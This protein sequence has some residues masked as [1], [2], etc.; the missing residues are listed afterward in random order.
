M[1]MYNYT[2]SK[3]REKYFSDIIGNCSNNSR[4]LFATVNRLTNP[5]AQLPLELIFTSKCNEFAVFFNDKVQGIKNAINSTTQITSM[6]PQRHLELNHFA[7]VTDKTVLEIVTSL[8]SST[9]C[10]DMLPTRF[11]KSVLNSLLSPLT[12]IVNMSLQSGTFPNALK[13]AVI[14][15]LL[16]K[17]SLDATVLNNFRP[18]S[19]LPFFGKVLEKAVL[20]NFLQ[21]NNSFDVFQ[22]GCRSTTALRL[23]LSR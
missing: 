23:L 10:L 5:P 4:V 16:K 3:T 7:R 15:P 14:K 13:T 8:S 6:Q 12:H 17:S 11:L 9:C 18:I 22:S 2:L 1:H 20:M 21:M 19:N